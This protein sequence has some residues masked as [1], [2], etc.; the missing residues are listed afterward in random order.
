MLKI[1]PRNHSHCGDKKYLSCCLKQRKNLKSTQIQIMCASPRV[2]AW[3][4]QKIHL[5]LKVADSGIA[6]QKN[7]VKTQISTRL[8]AALKT[9]YF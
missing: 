3:M 2:L 9:M 6:Y 8:K 7:C 5:L 4:Q 1:V